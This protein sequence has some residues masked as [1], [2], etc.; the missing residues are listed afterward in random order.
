MSYFKGK[1]YITLYGE[2]Y[3][4]IDIQ[5]GSEPILSISK[6]DVTYNIKYDSIGGI[7]DSQFLTY[8][9]ESPDEI[10]MIKKVFITRGVYQ[11]CVT[12]MVISKLDFSLMSWVKVTSLDNHV[13]FIS[14]NTRLCCSAKELGLTRGCVYF[15]QPGE[16]TLYKYDLDDK[17]VMLSL[18][19]PDLPKPW[20][21]PNWL[22]IP[23]TLC[24]NADDQRRGT[25]PMSG[26]NSDRGNNTKAIAKSSLAISPIRTR[27][28]IS[29]DDEKEDIEIARL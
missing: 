3:L 15:T 20:F 27:T 13:L 12:N 10:F 6:I 14:E 1:L 19:C 2:E 7:L 18:P 26:N 4:E 29:N 17:A 8:Y 5:D 16:M 28:S 25:E 11:D 24:R 9:V 23:T 22:M 21:S